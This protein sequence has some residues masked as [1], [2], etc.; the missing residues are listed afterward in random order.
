[1]PMFRI[2]HN[3]KTLLL[4]RSFFFIQWYCYLYKQLIFTENSTV[5]EQHFSSVAYLIQRTFWY[6]STL[7]LKWWIFFRSVVLKS[8]GTG[9]RASLQGKAT[10]WPHP[11]PSALPTDRSSPST[12]SSTPIP[13]LLVPETIHCIYTL[14]APNITSKFPWSF[15]D[16]VSQVFH[17]EVPRQ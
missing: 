6:W 13:K 5:D 11:H 16:F 2:L 14:Y 15:L 7:V 3:V 17:S 9:F 1:M 8:F 10:S 4:L 12:L